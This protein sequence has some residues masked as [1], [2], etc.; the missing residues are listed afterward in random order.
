MNTNIRKENGNK[1]L[2]TLSTTITFSLVHLENLVFPNLVFCGRSRSLLTIANSMRL[3]NTKM[4]QVAIQTSIACQHKGSS[5]ASF[6]QH[7]PWCRRREGGSP[8]SECSAW[9]EWG[10]SSPPE[11]PSLQILS[12]LAALPAQSHLPGVLS[13]GIQKLIQLIT[14]INTEGM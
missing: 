11:W 3:R 14:T 2:E 9:R 1:Y 4:M 6:S 12:V 7:W 13:G 10:G 5:G 8:G